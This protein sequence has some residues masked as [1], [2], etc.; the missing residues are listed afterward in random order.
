MATVQD[1]ASIG[2]SLMVK[3]VIQLTENGDEAGEA[4]GKAV[5]AE[6]VQA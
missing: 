4:E 1:E 3:P 6:V 5:G 2:M